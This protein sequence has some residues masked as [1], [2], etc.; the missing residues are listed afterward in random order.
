MASK[1]D[2]IREACCDCISDLRYK[3][4]A[5]SD[6]LADN[7]HNWAIGFAVVEGGGTGVFGLPGMIVDIPATITLALRTVHKIGLCYGY[8]A[9]SEE[10]KQFI[11]GILAASGAN[12]IEEKS[13]ALLYLKSIEQMLLKQT[14]KHIETVAA[15]QAGK[16]ASVMAI[17][18]IAKQLGINITKRKALAAI[19]FIGA[20]IGGSVNGWY[21]NEVS[22]AAKRAYQ[23]RWLVENQKI[24]DI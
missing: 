21:L 16:E 19:P 18:K 4:L 12:T 1:D 2:I 11:L 7:V 14:W 9:D 22:W 13:F 10:D 23:E 17:R 15:R 20:V 3:D 24:I 8:E 6:K 5:I